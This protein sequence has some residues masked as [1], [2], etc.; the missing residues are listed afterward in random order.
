M[1]LKHMDDSQLAALVL[2]LGLAFIFAYAGIS[3][4]L[5]PVEW[6]G[7]LPAFASAVVS[8]TVIVQVM[9]VVETALAVW[10]VSGVYLF[11]AALVGTLILAGITVTN[12]NVLIITFRDVGLVAA[13]LA[14]VLL[15]RARKS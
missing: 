4:F 14:L 6:A 13:A 8:A 11:Y 10:L 12:L 15:S 1:A 9:A 5:N 7:Y 2:R 3:S